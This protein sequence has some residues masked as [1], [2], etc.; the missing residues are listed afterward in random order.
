[1]TRIALFGARADQGGL[2][3]LTL[4]FFRHMRPAKTLVIDL[5]AAGRGASRL[6]RYNDGSAV[7]VNYGY[8]DDISP[9]LVKR[10]CEDIDVVYCAETSYRDDV[11]DIMRAQ[12]VCTVLHAMTEL[13]RKDMAPPDALWVPTDWEIGRMPAGAEVVPVPVALDRFPTVHV[14][15]YSK[16]VTFLFPGAP[17]FHDRNGL[18]VVIDALAHVHQ[19][20]RVILTNVESYSRDLTMATIHNV[21]GTQVTL[22]RREWEAENY[23]EHYTSDVDALLLPRRYGGLSLPMNEAA[24]AGLPIV[25]LDLPPQNEWILSATRAPAKPYRTVPMVNG[26]FDV[27]TADPDGIGAAMDVLADPEMYRNCAEE[28]RWHAEDVS[29][30]ALESVYSDRLGVVCAPRRQPMAAAS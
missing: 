26:T 13:Y 10:F 21:H 6:D 28:S 19:P 29:W 25:T 1:M 8:N 30:D 20:C 22:E 17:A 3:A 2:A 11:F 14:R 9:D 4:E 27:Y 24:A 12:G 15:D 5:G 7:Q 16:P 23:W 18:Q